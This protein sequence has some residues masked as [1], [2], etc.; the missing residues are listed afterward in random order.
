MKISERWLR[1][2]VSPRLDAKALAERLTMAGL[3]VGSVTAAGAP[4]AG[5]VVGEIRAV[6]P[7][8]TADRLHLCTVSLGKGGTVQIVCGAEN[9]RAG[10]KA[11]VALP[12]AVLPNGSTI[13]ETDVRGEHSAGMLC[14]AAEL[15][16]EEKSAGLLDLGPEA[17]LGAAVSDALA[18]DDVVL[19]VEL[20]P[21]RGDCLSLRGLA[22]EVSTL[23]GAK[24]AGPRLRTIKARSKRRFDVKLEAAADC[25]RYVG[26]VIEA[27]DPKAVTPLWMRERLRRAG[28]RAIHPVVDVTNYV[29]LELGQPMHGFDLDKLRGRIV[30]RQARGRESLALLDGSAVDVD[31][32][33]LLI[34]DQNGP[35]AL[36]GIMGGQNSAVGEGT[37]NIFLE[38][39]YFRAETVAGRARALGKQSE[40]SHRFERG[41]DPS[42]QREAMERA[43]ELL[44]AIAGG[45]AGPVI[46]RSA[47]KFLPKTKPIVLREN[48]VELLLGTRIAANAIAAILKGLGMRVA[49]SGRSFRVTPPSWRFDVRREV[50]LI[51]ELARVHGY[52]RIPSTRPK[53]E[54][55]APPAAEGRIHESRLRTALVDREYHEVI[56]YSFV[57]PKLQSRIEPDTA[58]LM[59]ANPI[60]ADMAA[61]RTSL[62]PG[63]LQTVVYNQNRQQTRMRLF[64]IGR[65]F[66]PAG[67]DLR[68]ES[69]LAGVVVGSAA[70]EQWGVAL[71]AADFHD[72]KADLEALFALTGRSDALDFVPAQHPALHPGQSASVVLAGETVGTLGTLHPEIQTKLGLDRTAVVFEVSLHALTQ[73]RIPRFREL[74]R[75]PALRRDLALVVADDVPARSVLDCVEKAAGELLVNLELFDEYRGKG[76]DSGRKSLALGLTLQDSSRTLKEAE[77]DAVVS[78]VIAALQTDLGA[79]LRS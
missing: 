39:A 41:V 58:P 73:A 52:D 37:C 76:I 25:P 35:V 78:R 45:R 28:Q 6:A 74:S 60:S 38:S 79:Q 21:N 48:R 33:T 7:H 71:R 44:L 17:R 50:D 65:R 63:L 47:R 40:S 13:K 34:A 20:T 59:L 32:G 51:E 27:I 24:L 15:G 26:R 70:A 55:T 1:E 67:D 36:A 75:F 14:S 29:M 2:W 57:D 5:V 72:V 77:V 61:M 10:M 49:R 54:M 31:R 69:C 23:T 4:L 11:P 12:G 64:E 62:W 18:L 8:P 16:L 68:Q 66:R 19:E 46:E 43:T 53:I 3:E 42:R 56:T 22:R 30:V 9:V